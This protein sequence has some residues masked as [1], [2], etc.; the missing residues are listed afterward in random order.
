MTT[1][2]TYSWQD[3]ASLASE[4]AG[5]PDNACR[6]IARSAGLLDADGKLDG[7]QAKTVELADG[8]QSL[9]VV[10]GICHDDAASGG[11][12]GITFAFES[13]VARRA[14]NNNA[15]FVDLS[16]WSGVNTAGGWNT[17]ELRTWLNSAFADLL[18]SDL[19]AVLV[20]VVKSSVAIDMGFG[21]ILDDG[22]YDASLGSYI[23][24][25]V[26]RLWLPAFAEVASIEQ[27]AIL[28]AETESWASV[29]A[30]EGTQYQLFADLGAGSDGPNVARA[31]T[32]PT[33]I[34]SSGEDFA[35]SVDT[36]IIDSPC[37]WWLRT[38]CSNNFAEVLEDGTVSYAGKSPSGSAQGI[39][40]LFA[41]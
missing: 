9:A 30:Q 28:K 33:R 6:E 4:L 14:M 19:E 5:A 35:S 2:D 1:L 8:T 12:A 7:T 3:L 40:P 17:C 38:T 41:I 32:M 31:K 10:A 24:A 15:G 26:D 39:L 18:P 36:A 37:R 29:L 25:G 27:A 34:E 21:L 20:P 23:E 22:S 13:P 11:K 16:E